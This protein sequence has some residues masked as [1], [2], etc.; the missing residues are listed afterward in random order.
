MCVVG[1]LH[2]GFMRDAEKE[3]SCVLIVLEDTNC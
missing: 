1:I 2:G 3:W